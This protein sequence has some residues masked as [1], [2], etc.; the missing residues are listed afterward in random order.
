MQKL[1]LCLGAL[2]VSLALAF[3]A[4]CD[5]EGVPKPSLPAPSSASSSSDS[6][7]PLR[8]RTV[9]AGSYKDDIQPIFNQYCAECHGTK[10]AENGL[11]LDTYEGVIAGTKFGPVVIAG[12]SGTSALL[13]VLDGTAASEIQ[14]PHE[15][16]RLSRNRLANIRAWVDAGAK[17]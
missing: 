13:F 7:V 1:S 17:Q 15:A 8:L 4:G 10:R 11:R 12:S 5:L 14:M 3:L 6:D 9:W 16:R 2:V